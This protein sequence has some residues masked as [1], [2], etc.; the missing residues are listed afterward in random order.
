MQGVLKTNDLDIETTIITQPKL[1]K[2]KQL[3]AA[4]INSKTR[5]ALYIE[6]PYLINPFG[7][8][9]YDGGKDIK[10][11]AKS[12]S[13]VLKAQ[14]SQ[15]DSAEEIT[16]LFN[17]FKALDEKTIDYGLEHSQTIFKKKYDESQRAIL[18]DLLYNRCVKPSVG[19]DGTVYPDKITL[20]VMKKLDMSPDVLLFKDTSEP[21][22]IGTWDE[23]QNS[24]P[25]GVP[26]KAIIQPR[27][28]FVNGKMGINFRVLQIKLQ[29]VS[30]VGRPIT[31]AFSDAPIGVP[32]SVFSPPSDDKPAVVGESA[33]E[34][35]DSEGE[36]ED[37]EDDDDDEEEV[38]DA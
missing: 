2:N 11:E 3:T 6:T 31:Y 34:V 7:L 32:E 20:K 25:K 17:Y 37:E 1:N 23:L 36:D 22:S 24:I 4:I 18:V 13:L 8:S 33:E 14:G 19:G 26:L 9:A 15:N 28:Y 21:L 29:S 5:S 12:W 16:A 35:E 10:E 27:L 30:K 38:T